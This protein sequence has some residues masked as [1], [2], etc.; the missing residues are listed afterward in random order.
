MSDI[1]EKTGGFQWS[2]TILY[3]SLEVVF[4]ILSL[5]HT[6]QLPGARIQEDCGFAP[7]LPPTPVLLFS[8]S[9]SWWWQHTYFTLTQPWYPSCSPLSSVPHS[10]KPLSLSQE[11][12]ALYFAVTLK[13]HSLDLYWNVGEVECSFAHREVQQMCGACL[14][15]QTDACVLAQRQATKE[16]GKTQDVSHS[17][18]SRGKWCSNLL[19]YIKSWLDVTSSLHFLTCPHSVCLLSVQM[20]FRFTLKSNRDACPCGI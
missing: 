5:C 15:H 9:P 3:S 20:F 18:Q 17:Q 7:S 14:A 16:E 8:I 13:P 12:W 10:I 6:I 1:W 4:P 2:N 19:S 11:T